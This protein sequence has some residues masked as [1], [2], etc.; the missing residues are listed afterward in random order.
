MRS[1]IFVCLVLVSSH[2]AK[3]QWN[4]GTLADPTYRT[5]SVGIGAAPGTG[6]K[7]DIFGPSGWD[8][9]TMVRI[10]NG[11]T[12]YGRTNLVLVGRIQA[13]NDAWSFGSEARNSLV[14]SG[15]IRHLA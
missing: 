12:D 5:G 4:P 13:S 1:I 8:T 14:F 10:V 3:A 11:A 2:L 7:L 6:S 9:R 15:T